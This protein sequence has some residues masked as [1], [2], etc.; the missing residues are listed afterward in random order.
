M[1]EKEEMNFEDS[2]VPEELKKDD[3]NTSEKEATEK[4]LLLEGDAASDI[5]Q[6]CA[7]LIRDLEQTD[8]SEVGKKTENDCEAVKD[9]DI[10]LEDKTVVKE[11][12]KQEEHTNKCD[13]VQEV[14]HHKEKEDNTVHTERLNSDKV[15][16]LNDK[17]SF[18]ECSE[19]SVNLAKSDPGIGV[20]PETHVG[21]QG[22]YKDCIAAV[23]LKH[24]GERSDSDSESVSND[25]GLE[26]ITSTKLGDIEASNKR[27]KET[28]KDQEDS[29]GNENKEW[30]NKKCI[31]D[32][33][34]FSKICDQKEQYSIQA[35]CDSLVQVGNFSEEKISETNTA[36]VMK[37]DHIGLRN[38][39]WLTKAKQII[40]YF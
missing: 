5:D 28:P 19:A 36:A 32:G 30:K 40:V 35:I 7:E 23:N 2:R 22:G 10:C 29:I 14:M 21:P 34:S 20:G 1:E 26:H 39:I 15:Q 12:S 8:V 9:I 17:K 25:I 37:P 27:R 33:P 31:K 11:D 3:E 6:D 18:Q 16:E 4:C 13:K 38:T 24:I